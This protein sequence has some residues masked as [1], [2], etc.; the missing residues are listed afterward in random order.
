LWLILRGFD[1]LVYDVQVSRGLATQASKPSQ[2]QIKVTSDQPS[3]SGGCGAACGCV[4][5]PRDFY[6]CSLSSADCYD[7]LVNLSLPRDHA[8]VP[9]S[10]RALTVF[11]FGFRMSLCWKRSDF[12]KPNTLLM[13][14]HFIFY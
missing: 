9:V 12:E 3:D 14:N 2:K 7:D 6:L 4:V 1:V 5:A 10:L 13:L 11:H 8:A